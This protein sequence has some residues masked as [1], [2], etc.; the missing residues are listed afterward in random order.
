MSASDSSEEGEDYAYGE[1][2]VVESQRYPIHDCCE[3]EDAEALRVSSIDSR[4]AVSCPLAVIEGTILA[5]VFR[6]AFGDDF[7]L[8]ICEKCVL[9][10]II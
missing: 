3:F 7:L 2:Q 6:S 4:A 8:I 5:P 9:I 10:L 1:K